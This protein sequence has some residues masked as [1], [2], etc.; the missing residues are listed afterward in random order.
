VEEYDKKRR[1]PRVPSENSVMVTKLSS[2]GVEGFTKT[3]VVGLGGCLIVSDVSLGVG[4]LLE[5]RIAIR[6]RVARTVGRVL[7]ETPK[8]G[9]ELEVG[10]EFVE[11]EE[12]DREI[13]RG[14]LSSSD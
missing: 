6:G 1:F 11:I 14:L 7:Y 10:V 5:I 2:D 8:T 3:R 13:I 9:G 12:P 4:S